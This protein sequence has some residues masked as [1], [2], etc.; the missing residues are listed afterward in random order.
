MSCYHPLKIFYTGRKTEKGKKEGIVTK[1][2][3]EFFPLKKAW[4]RIGEKFWP[5][6]GYTAIIRESGE[7]VLIQYDEIPCG[8]CI[9]CRKDRAADWATRIEMEIRATKQRAWFLTITYDEANV[10][11]TLSKRDMQL[12]IKRLRKKH[13]FRYYL[14]G[15]YGEKTGR[16][17]YHMIAIGLEPGET[18]K[19]D[20]KQYVM[21]D[22]EKAWGKGRILGAPAEPGAIA[23]VTGYVTKKA[24]Q[25]EREWP[26]GIE[27]PFQLMSRRPGIGYEGIGRPEISGK[28]YLSGA[29][30]APRYVKNK[31]EKE[32]P[33]LMERAKKAA[34]KAAESLRLNDEHWAAT[35]RTEL[36]NDRKEAICKS[37]QKAKLRNK[38]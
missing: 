30:S 7:I 28:I 26:E 9:G 10:P 20:K 13:E 32:N 14:A 33:E 3:G 24:Y 4:A 21:L 18:K 15:E 19:W 27:K 12:F 8:H 17:H 36:I 6:E 22:L 35:N 34:K 2:E 38:I 31:W 16:P 1:G 25:L 37:K 29:R 5:T 11:P 23:Y